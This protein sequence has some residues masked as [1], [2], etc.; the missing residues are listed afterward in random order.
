MPTKKV[1]EK[2][3]QRRPV[4]PNDAKESA[5]MNFKTNAPPS[6][7][8]N[9]FERQFNNTQLPFFGNWLVARPG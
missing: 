6:L 7:R 2:T 8:K 3:W 1:P 9:H 4:A 5:H